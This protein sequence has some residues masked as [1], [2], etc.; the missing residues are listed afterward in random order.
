MYSFGKCHICSHEGKFCVSV[1]PAI[2]LKL[3][4][5]RIDQPPSFRLD[6]KSTNLNCNLSIAFLTELLIL[7]PSFNISPGNMT[8]LGFWSLHLC[9]LEK[10]MIAQ[11]IC[12]Q[13]KKLVGTLKIVRSVNGNFPCYLSALFLPLCKTTRTAAKFYF[14][15]TNHKSEPLLLLQR[16]QNMSKRKYVA[17]PGAIFNFWTKYKRSTYN[18]GYEDQ[19]MIERSKNIQILWLLNIY[20]F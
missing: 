7:P 1:Y 5:V 14:G 3:L 6:I 9:C 19:M 13:S 11:R 10:E 2:N 16:V 12:S 4:T 15:K 20:Q 18:C 17:K 8:F